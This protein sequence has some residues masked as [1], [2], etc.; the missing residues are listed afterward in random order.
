VDKQQQRKLDS[1]IR[2]QDFFATNPELVGPV[3]DLPAAKEIAEAVGQVRQHITSQGAITMVVAG[4]N[5]RIRGMAEN[6]VRQHLAPIASFSRVALKGVPEYAT[7]SKTVKGNSPKRVV[8]HAFA[9]AKA[10]TTYVDAMTTAGFPS[11]TVDQLL[12]ATKELD[13]VI[14]KREPLAASRVMS[15]ESIGELLE[16]GRD[17]VRK[18]DA[19]LSRR[20]AVDA[21]ALAAWKATSRVQFQKGYVRK[22]ALME[23]VTIKP[24]VAGERVASAETE[25]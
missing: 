10:A 16:R 17:G 4:Q 9:V 14:M 20:L 12:A 21:P 25:K 6:I 11:D 1:L 18:I 13:D 3:A 7:L 8:S 22:P 5:G 2:V 19:V 15:T 24:E 23:P